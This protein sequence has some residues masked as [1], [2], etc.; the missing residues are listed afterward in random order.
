M[1]MQAVG[2]VDTTNMTEEQKREIDVAA[3]A[4]YMEAFNSAASQ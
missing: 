4:D 1:A 3:S 2:M